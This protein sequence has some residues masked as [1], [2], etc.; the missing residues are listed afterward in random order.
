MRCLSA[1]PAEGV[2]F[3]HLFPGVTEPGTTINDW[4][5]QIEAQDARPG[6]SLHPGA[7]HKPYFVTSCT[8]RLQTEG[9]RL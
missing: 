1:Q 7:I 4:T 3:F 6:G 8:C 5:M 9:E 2:D